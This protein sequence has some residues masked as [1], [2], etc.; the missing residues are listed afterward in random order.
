VRSL[1]VLGPALPSD[2]LAEGWDSVLPPCPRP[3]WRRAEVS[4]WLDDGVL[5]PSA[6]DFRGERQN[7][8]SAAI[9]A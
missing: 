7:W 4:F 2:A 1:Q 5:T 6:D 9:K 8:G 3:P